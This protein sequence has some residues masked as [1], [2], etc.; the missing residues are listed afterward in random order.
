MPS[1]LVSTR[2]PL[3]PVEGGRLIPPQQNANDGRK[4]PSDVSLEPSL[5][6]LAIHR[7]LKLTASVSLLPD[8]CA[9]GHRE[10]A[11]ISMYHTHQVIELPIIRPEVTHWRLHQGQCL[12]C[13]TLCKALLPSEHASGY[14]PRLTSLVGEMAGMVG[15]AAVRCKTCAPRC[16]V[17]PSVKERSRRWWIEYPRRSC[18]ITRRLAQWLAP[19]W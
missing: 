14:G 17:L 16:A 10:F 13:G 8:A 15:P 19:L 6:M 12:S 18:P 11:E 5:A 1:K 7:C 9:C 2:T 3:T 4:L